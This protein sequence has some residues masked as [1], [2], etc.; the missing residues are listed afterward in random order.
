VVEIDPLNHFLESNES[1]NIIV[2]DLILNEQSEKQE[3]ALDLQGSKILC[4][5]ETATLTAN[6]GNSVLWSTGETTQSIEI[7]EPGNY[8]CEIEVDCGTIYSDTIVFTNETLSAPSVT[9]MIS[10]C[11]PEQ[12]TIT[13]QN[14]NGGLLL[15]YSDPTTN[16]LLTTGNTFQTPLIN[17]TTTYWL[18]EEVFI[19]GEQFNAGMPDNLSGSTAIN[20]ADYNGLLIFDVLTPFTLV[21]VRTYADNSGNR[22]FQILDKNDNVIHQKTV[23]ISSGEDRAILNFPLDMGINYKIQC[24]THPGFYRNKNNVQYPY[25]VP[26]IVKIKETNY[27]NLFYYYFYDW[28][29]RLADRTCYSE[30]ANTSIEFGSNNAGN[31]QIIGL[32]P[33]I[34]STD[35]YILTGIPAGGT[36]SGNGMQQND[37]YTGTLNTGLNTITYT[38]GTGTACENST[39]STVL[40]Y[41]RNSRFADLNVNTVVP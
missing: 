3:E 4:D 10:I 15:W 5:G 14:N 33:I 2:A 16:N 18:K 40:I 32:P 13:A 29:L 11:E 25:E 12:L 30:V 6:Y 36:F 31:A 39:D 24:E 34:E 41:K 22:T 35:N 8:F 28:E 9:D 7:S 19:P 37:F 38:G 20:G 1:N 26:G 17:N 23:F 27:G 21:S